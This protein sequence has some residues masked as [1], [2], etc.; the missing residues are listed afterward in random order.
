MAEYIV[1]F[2]LRLP[3]WF[4]LDAYLTQMEPLDKDDKLLSNGFIWHTWYLPKALREEIKQLKVKL[5]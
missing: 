2:L 5:T 3:G 4:I 1:Y